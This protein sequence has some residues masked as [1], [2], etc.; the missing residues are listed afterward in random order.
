[1]DRWHSPGLE[2][3]CLDH[4][5]VVGSDQGLLILDGPAGAA[6]S[7][8]VAATP[9]RNLQKVELRCL[10]TSSAAAASRHVEAHVYGGS[11]ET[12]DSPAAASHR[13]ETHG[14]PA[15]AH[16]HGKIPRKS[17]KEGYNKSSETFSLL[18]L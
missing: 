15:V 14:A 12:Q 1:M 13:V 10:H 9:E 4:I 18:C 16:R 5:W 7:L 17:K 8:Q 3:R 6:R 11:V 2:K